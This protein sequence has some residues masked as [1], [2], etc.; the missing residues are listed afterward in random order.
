MTGFK[1]KTVDLNKVIV[2]TE[3]ANVNP[4]TG[5]SFT[6]STADK[7]NSKPL[8]TGY[9]IGGTEISNTARAV[10]EEIE[11]TRQ[12]SVPDGAKTFRFAAVGGGGGGGGGG[13]S[14]CSDY[15]AIT[16]A[17]GGHGGHGRAGYY[18]YYTGTPIT[19]SSTIQVTIG[20]GGGGGEGGTGKWHQNQPV[21]GA[22]GTAGQ[23]GNATTLKLNGQ[24]IANAN[25]GGSGNLGKGGRAGDGKGGTG[26]RGSPGNTSGDSKGGD[27]GNTNPGITTGSTNASSDWDNS[28]LTPYGTRGAYGTGGTAD[29][30]ETA[31][32]SNSQPDKGEDG[33][34]GTAGRAVIIWLYQ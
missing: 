20:T 33:A 8:N 2:M 14:S 34:P 25:G 16:Y 18:R 26:N 5:Y 22:D 12:V 31:A 29:D 7:A 19:S 1:F 30:N 21:T 15:Y 3:T 9:I 13:G 10:S 4:D 23:A 32:V 6:Y 11:E 27:N 24:T 28:I 17:Q